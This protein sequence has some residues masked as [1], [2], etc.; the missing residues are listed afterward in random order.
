MH[1]IF[2]TW[3]RTTLQLAIIAILALVLMCTGCA[4]VSSGHE[5][6]ASFG[7]TVG[8]GISIHVSKEIMNAPPTPTNISRPWESTDPQ[9]QQSRLRDAVQDLAQVLK[10][11]T[12]SNVVIETKA[13]EQGQATFP[14]LIGQLANDRFGPVTIES[15][16]RQGLRIVVQPDAIG[17]LG[18]SDLATNYAIYTFLDDLGCRWYMPGE[19]GEVIPKVKT[20]QTPLRD[21]SLKPGTLLRSMWYCGAEYARRNRLGGLPMS[22]THALDFAYLS[23]DTLKAHPQWIATVDGKPNPHRLKWSS[24][25]LADAIAKAMNKRLDENPQT[26]TLS[27]SPNDGMGYDNSPEELALD[28]GDFDEAAQMVSITDRLIWFCNQIVE[29]IHPKHPNVIF[30]LLAYANYNRPPVREKVHPSIVPQIAPITFSRAHPMTDDREPNNK[31]LRHILQGWAK[32]SSRLSYYLYAFFLAEPSAPNPMMTKWGT[33]LPILYQN[34]CQFWQPETIPN[35][36]TSMHA[37]VLGNRMAWDPT[38]KPEHVFN[39]LHTKFYGHAAK[40]MAEYWRYVDH[41]WVDPAEFAGCGYG[42]LHRFPLQKMAEARRLMEAAVASCKTDMEKKR[43]A[44]AQES[45]SLFEDFMAMRH[46]L[47]DGR[48][49]GLATKADAYM[50]RQRELGTRHQKDYAFSKMGWTK[51]N[52]LYGVYFN[53]FFNDTYQDA[54]RIA[55]EFQLLTNPPLREW[56]YRFDA[57]RK[58]LAEKWQMPEHDDRQW[59]ST[60]IAVD[61][62]SAMG[63]PNAIGPMWYR[64]LITIPADVKGKR[65]YIWLSATDGLTR[66]YVNGKTVKYRDAKGK[67][68][69]AFRGFSKP[70]SF[71]ISDAIKT[72]QTNTIAICSERE[73][74]NE[75]GV[76]GLMGPVV[77]YCER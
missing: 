19:L 57:D 77:I 21:V 36:E 29:D 50:A 61:T 56:C 53:I 3:L 16:Y 35:F 17:L 68:L 18:Q 1:G 75:L 30:G 48:Y 54:D 41:L 42:H 32:Q 28:T 65:V 11:M 37:L 31:A 44:L 26:L 10:T 15:T 14:I 47:A 6:L 67:E 23:K 59:S 5:P 7:R 49:Q 34:N 12:G 45:L 63:L 66:I 33:D 62:W 58:G 13:P 27:L 70:V 24:P 38:L 76:G 51:D 25:G 40:S 60:D 64:K 71:D 69:E 9:V 22:S 20:I 4:G 55:T 72:G 46:D 43:V 2:L 39:E 8:P 74:V 52:S 73:V